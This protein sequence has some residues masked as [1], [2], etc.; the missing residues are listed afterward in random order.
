[1]SSSSR[2]GTENAKRGRKRLE[3]PEPE[4]SREE[5]LRILVE[6]ATY[7]G[8][9]EPKVLSI[10]KKAHGFEQLALRDDGKSVDTGAFLEA[11]EDQLRNDI[12]L[13]LKNKSEFAKRLVDIYDMSGKDAKH[14]PRVVVEP[15]SP[16]AAAAQEEKK[17]EEED[18][19]PLREQPPANMYAQFAHDLND[20]AE[21]ALMPLVS[22]TGMVA[23]RT[24]IDDVRRLYAFRK[25]GAS[26]EARLRVFDE[27]VTTRAAFLANVRD[28]GPTLTTMMLTTLE[29]EAARIVDHMDYVDRNGGYSPL[30]A[31]FDLDELD[32]TIHSLPHI[33]ITQSRLN[34]G[35]VRDETEIAAL[36]AEYAALSNAMR[37]L[38]DD[39]QD[40]MAEL[41][42]R[43]RQVQAS[44]LQRR[45]ATQSRLI[46][47]ETR[48]TIRELG[49]TDVE[50]K[51]AP[52]WAFEVMGSAIYR[53]VLST[54][55]LASY[56]AALAQ[57]NRIPGCESF[58]MK[59]LICS[60][61]VADMFALLVASTWLSA[62]DGSNE[63]RYASVGTRSAGGGGR[64][65][66]NNYLNVTR[67]RDIMAE[68]VL[69]CK[70]WFESVIKRPNR[71]LAEFS[72]KLESMYREKVANA[73]GD[74][75]E[76]ARIQ[77]WK[78]RMMAYQKMMPQKELIYT[79]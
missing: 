48:E 39:D 22:F 23:A 66:T 31:C 58:T 28:A 53:R 64:N 21:R 24:R 12:H 79:G 19:V 20:L 1:M 77:V 38:D 65:R 56:E 10:I 76:L 61:S 73:N 74:D 67:V 2:G 37:A 29:Q 60:P 15:E 40:G 5:K 18:Q 8:D 26:P 71:L 9:V 68:K 11:A 13:L 4:Q 34:Q 33:A 16:P 27:T 32:H 6:D 7:D 75:D 36:E 72:A 57:V 46:L 62:G 35:L 43:A 51:F 14:S 54:T 50:R 49:I 42:Q 3:I 70:V 55:T 41:Q 47:Q 69:C 17:E 30:G 78:N 25:D 45:Q 44:I 63:P 52:A 59:E